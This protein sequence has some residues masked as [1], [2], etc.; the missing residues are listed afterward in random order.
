MKMM[1]P[2]TSSANLRIVPDTGFYVAAAFK[3]GYARSYLVGRGSKFLSYRLYSSEAILLELQRVLEETFHFER[4]QVVKA[5][6]DIRK[7]VEIV[8]PTRK[9]KV[10]R[11][12]DDDKILECAL[13]AKADIVLAFDKDLLVIKEFEGIKIIHPSMMQYIFWKTSKLVQKFEVRKLGGAKP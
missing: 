3:N 6:L 2:H 7:V 12:P 1:S 5:I 8:H 13:E 4:T 9:I 11:D 10:D